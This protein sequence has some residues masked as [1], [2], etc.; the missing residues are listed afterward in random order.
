VLKYIAA[1]VAFMHGVGHISGVLSAW[2]PVNT[3][4][5]DRPWIFSKGV[6]VKSPL[7]RL[8]GLI[9]LAAL[10]CLVAAGLGLAFGQA[11]WPMLLLV[12]AVVSLVAIVPWWNTVVPGARA[13][14]LFDLFILVGLLLWKDQIF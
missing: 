2:T 11:W 6:T 10:G 14:V 9:W 1:F 3:G 12:G 13:G 4:F 5:S 7:G 8:W